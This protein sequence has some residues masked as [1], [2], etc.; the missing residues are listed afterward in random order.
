MTSS[1]IES[2]LKARGAWLKATHGDP[3]EAAKHSVLSKHI[4]QHYSVYEKVRDH[5]IKAT[6]EYVH[7][8]PISAP[9]LSP[10]GLAIL[11]VLETHGM[12]MREPGGNAI[13]DTKSKRYLSGGWLE[14]LAWLAAMEAGA[15][16]AIYG[17]VIGWKVKEFTGENEIDLIVRKGEMLGFLS[18]KAFRSDLDMQDRKHRNRL[19]DSVHE[20]DNLGDHFGRPGEKVAVLVTTDLF[21]EDRNVARYNALMG[22]AAVLDVRIIA[23]EDL[24]WDRLVAA[25]A[26][27]FE[28]D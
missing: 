21:D 6:E 4:A 23:L 1:T 24:G 10:E 5:V 14:E 16:E 8:V 12:I 26:S 22:K 19:M 28:K 7:R 15:D 18:C 9:H 3:A 20:A 27:L 13:C 11:S 25:I 17:Q 2:I